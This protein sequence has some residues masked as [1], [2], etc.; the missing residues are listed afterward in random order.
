MS[1]SRLD[2]GRVADLRRRFGGQVIE[3]DDPDYDSARLVW[4]A[5]IDRRPALIVRPAG[6]ADVA[7]AIRFGREAGLEIAVKGGGHG[8]AGH[9]TVDDGLMIDLGSMHAVTVDTERSMVR[10]QGGAR[11]D[12]LDR[13]TGVH[14]LAVPAGVNW[15]TG[16][17]GLCLGGGYGWLARLH[18]LTC[19][20]LL[21]AEVVTADGEILV[22]EA[23]RDP[24]LLWGL[25]GGGGNFGIVTTF[26]LRAHPAPI[27]AH[28]LNLIFDPAAADEVCAAFFELAATWPRFI[29]GHM[30][31]FEGK[32]GEIPEAARGGPSIVAGFVAL[33]E[34]DE[35]ADV[36]AIAR[37]L[38]KV[39][40]PWATVPWSG[41]FRELQRESSEAPGARRRR[42]WKGHYLSD[43]SEA[44]VRQF[45]TIDDARPFY[46]EVEVFQLGGALSDRPA[47]A[48]AYGNRDAAFDILAI[49]YWDD[50]MEDEARLTALRAT[51]D[52]FEPF[53]SGVYLNNLVDDAEARVREA[54]LTERF[55]QLRALKTRLDPENVF[56]RNA[57]IPPLEASAD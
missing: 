55:D 11:L 21:R 12:D 19:D 52:R 37:P 9:A 10:A 43:V 32:G 28:N 41:T 42:Y 5:M 17:A 34:Q 27:R 39:A 13:E 2:L 33:D 50:P 56:H 47:D 44:F 54:F 51:A 20:N 29:T 16:V 36:A 4:N 25:C 53:S 40:E 1:G 48:T 31:V 24:E 8:P 38:T 22:A 23:E 46:Q 6:T 26:E 35:H 57:N 14:G 7:T 30:G 15:D 3:P 49:G 45:A 18:G